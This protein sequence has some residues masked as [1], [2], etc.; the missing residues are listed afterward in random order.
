MPR[1]RI[2]PLGRQHSLKEQLKGRNRSRREGLERLAAPSAAPH[3]LRNDRLPALEIS[4]VA[5]EELRSPARRLRVRD[6][7]HVRDVAASVSSLGFMSPL[8]LGKDD[9]ILDGEVRKEAGE[10]LEIDRLPC[11]RIGHLNEVQQRLVRLAVNRLGEKG[12]W[13][14][15]ELKIEFDELILSDARIEI[16]GF[17][18]DE[19][20]Q[21]TIGD[22]LGVVESGPLAPDVNLLAGARTGDIFQLGAHRV[23]CADATDPLTLK[24]L[25]VSDPPARIVLTDEPYNVPIAG[26]VTGAAQ[27][28]S[29]WLRAR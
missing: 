25:M 5:I 26:H 9:E 14:L 21:I 3:R 8:L 2:D 24:K 22:E 20:D 11:I 4:Y 23:I 27:V 29:K 6:P 10:L 16:S 12:Q 18:L 13:D 7:A 15:N 28:S 17:S 19:I 1:D